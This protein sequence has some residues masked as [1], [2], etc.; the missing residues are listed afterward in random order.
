MKRIISLFF[1]GFIVSLHVFSQRVDT[2]S[3][4][5][6]AMNKDLPALVITPA[7]YE[8]GTQ[9]PVVYLLHGFGSDYS[10]WYNLVQKRLPELASLYGFIIVC[11]TGENSWYF[12]S[13]LLPDSQFETYITSEVVGYI[14]ANYKTHAV[15]EARAISGFS[16]GGHGS[17]WLTSRHLDLFGACGSMSGVMD[18]KNSTQKYTLSQKLGNY[19]DNMAAWEKSSVMNNLT[20]L[21]PEQAPALIIDCGTEDTFFK[22]NVQLHE[23]L[24]NRG[25]SHD[26]TIRP[27]GHTIPYWKNAVL[28]HLLF[29]SEYFNSKKEEIKK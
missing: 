11:P 8:T 13:Q 4:H 22:E 12:D 15:K 29:F 1:L 2:I 24:Q 10:R 6:D 27:G 7:N 26:F 9:Y 19:E 14:D 3:I 17:L 16:M 28:Y 23:F 21:T 20:N 5:S 18:L 25:I